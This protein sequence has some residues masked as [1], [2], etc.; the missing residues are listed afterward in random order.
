M[1]QLFH[2]KIF[3][4]LKGEKRGGF[5]IAEEKFIMKPD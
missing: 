4:G 3:L 2:G 5:R 1:R